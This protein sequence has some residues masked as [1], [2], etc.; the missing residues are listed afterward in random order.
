MTFNWDSSKYAAISDLQAKVGYMLMDALQPQPHERIL[1]IGCGIGNLT[2]E[3]ASRC[4]D[5][6]VF[7]ID[8]SPSMISQAQI[9]SRGLA[10]VEFCAQDAKHL[11]FHQEFDAV[12]SNSALHWLSEG[13][14]VLVTIR[15]AL[16]PGG[17]IG[18]QF[19][20]LN[21]Q[22]PLIS[23]TRQVIKSLE[24]ERYYQKWRFPWFVTT[25]EAYTRLLCDAGYQNVTV[26]MMQTTHRFESPSQAYNFFEA[27]GLGLY[28]VPLGAEQIQHF[29]QVLRQELER[30]NTVPGILFHFERLFAFGSIPH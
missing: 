3:L 7:G 14:K 11:Q 4:H 9:R 13:D 24:L 21:E 27:V 6:F 15:T 25:E 2:V 30:A 17:R 10:N 29:Q 19:P 23:S 1:D 8:A 22:H 12:F 5:G 18:I 26:K 16:K 28:L 20:L